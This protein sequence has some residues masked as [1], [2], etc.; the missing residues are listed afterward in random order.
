M[1]FDV[2]VIRDKLTTLENQYT[3]IRGEQT[4][5]ESKRI[6]INTTLLRLE[7]AIVTIKQL[8]NEHHTSD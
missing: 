5:I 4:I 3:Q 1:G 2:D 7:G 6:E 8:L